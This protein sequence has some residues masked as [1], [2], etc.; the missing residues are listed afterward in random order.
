MQASSPPP[1]FSPYQTGFIG[2][3][4]LGDVLPCRDPMARSG[5]GWSAFSKQS[6]NRNLDRRRCAGI[7]PSNQTTT[8]YPNKKDGGLSRGENELLPHPALPLR[9]VLVQS[10]PTGVL[11][12][13]Q[14]RAKR[15]GVALNR[16]KNKKSSGEGHA[17]PSSGLR[18]FKDEQ[19]TLLSGR[20]WR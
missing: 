13:S 14:R 12:R 11:P 7:Q 2:I 19:K 20:E 17:R 18:L 5:S 4:L 9:L 6:I 3:S 1:S 10:S 16:R 8:S 15:G